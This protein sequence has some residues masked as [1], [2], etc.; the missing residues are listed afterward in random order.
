[1]DERMDIDAA[2]RTARLVRRLRRLNASAA[3]RRVYPLVGALVALG[4][5]VGLLFRHSLTEGAAPTPSWNRYEVA[6]RLVTYGYLTCSTVSALALLGYLLGRG[7]DRLRALAM[8]DPLT[9]LSNRRLL[10][11]RIAEEARRAVRYQVP[12]AVLALDVDGLRRVNDGLGHRAGDAALRAVAHALSETTRATDIAAR[13]G[14]DEFMVFLLQTTEEEAVACARRLLEALAAMRGP[15]T[16]PLS[17][18][19]GSSGSTAHD[20]R[21]ARSPSTRR[22]RSCT[23]PGPAA[24][25]GSSCRRLYRNGAR[26][27]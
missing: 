25:A 1:M 26:S 10:A 8:T 12:L 7:T 14:G 4:P 16:R 22:T 13:T 24:G 9:G 21:T 19:T 15:W 3:R 5:P 23:A 18:S 27:D 2:G 11:E 17:V 6:A 20:R